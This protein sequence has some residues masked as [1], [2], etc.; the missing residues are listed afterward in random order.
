MS[1]E[2]EGME[3][4]EEMLVDMTID[5]SDEKKAMREAIKP[6]AKEI[7]MN[8]PIGKTG[9]LK[10]LSKTVKKDGLATVGII[11]T[12]MFYDRFQEFGTSKQK[13][14]IGFFSNSVDNTTD[15]AL[16]I[17]TKELLDKAK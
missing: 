2:V 7:E 4:F 3:E 8:T 9:R 17:L 12:K 15:K 1:I 5:K 13:A 6:I 16:E 10:K 11:R 14:N